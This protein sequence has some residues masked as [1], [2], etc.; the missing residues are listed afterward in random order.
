MAH[1]PLV[2]VYFAVLY[3]STSE[4][5]SSCRHIEVCTLIC[6]CTTLARNDMAECFSEK[7]TEYVKRDRRGRKSSDSEI[8]RCKYCLAIY[9]KIINYSL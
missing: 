7:V 2:S 9:I 1:G 5:Q 6:V 3:S 4:M 8:R